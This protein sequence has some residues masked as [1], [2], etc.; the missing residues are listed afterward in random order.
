MGVIVHKREVIERVQSI[1]TEIDA[2][3]DSSGEF[4]TAESMK[5]QLL[6]GD[7]NRFLGLE[8]EADDLKTA[9]RDRK[10]NIRRARAE[11][12]DRAVAD[13]ERERAH[14]WLTSHLADV[15]R[16]NRANER[17]RKINARI[18]A[19]ARRGEDDLS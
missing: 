8:L 1:L 6:A 14:G 12:H 16:R 7:L 9:E 4:R 2:E 10:R 18:R 17:R 19:A 11:E 3:L 5:V 13:H 15:A